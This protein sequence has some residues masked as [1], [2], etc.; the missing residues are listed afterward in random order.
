MFIEKLP[1]TVN[2]NTLQ[3]DL[4]NIVNTIGWPEK[5]IEHDG[6]AYH[7][8]QLGLTYRKGATHPWHD[9]SGSLYDKDQK[10]FTGKESDFTEW[11]NIGNATRLAIEELSN[12]TGI[13]FGRCRYMRLMPKTGLSVHPDFECRYHLVFKTNPHAYFLDCEP[14]GATVAKAYHI[15]A[16]GHFY[17]VD[18]TRNHTVFNGGWEERIHLVLAEII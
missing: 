10:H 15:P 16:D 12:S 8:N 7:A 5:K 3:T 1:F 6:R 4:D 17:K 2:L 9:A 14:D 18:T 13:K 11:N